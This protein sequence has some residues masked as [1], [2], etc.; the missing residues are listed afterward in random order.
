MA[1]YICSKHLGKKHTVLQYAIRH[2]KI[3]PRYHLQNPFYSPENPFSIPLMFRKESAYCGG[4][5]RV[6]PMKY[7]F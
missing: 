4:T 3:K 6:L 2:R 5:C 1:K 7:N